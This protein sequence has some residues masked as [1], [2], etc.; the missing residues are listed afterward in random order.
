[1][2][3]EKIMQ[4]RELLKNQG[5][6]ACFSFYSYY[7]EDTEE[8]EDRPDTQFG[9]C[10]ITGERCQIVQCTTLTGADRII[11][12]DVDYELVH[13]VLGKLCGAF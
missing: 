3:T 9:V 6:T 2:N 10:D 13:G 11:N 7:D 1:M 8:C 4:L 5:L 12:L